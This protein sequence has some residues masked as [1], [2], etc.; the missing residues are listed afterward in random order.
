M[1]QSYLNTLV[2]EMVNKKE[3]LKNHLVD[4][5]FIGGGTP[6][7]L[8][9]GGIEIIINAIKQNFTVLES[10]EITMEINP[11]AITQELANEWKQAGI[12]RVSVGLQSAND[13]VLKTIGRTHKTA[14]FVSAMQLLKNAGFKNRNADLML[15]LPN[16]TVADVKNAVNLV[17]KQG[18]THVSA[19][20]LILEDETPLQKLVE[21]NLVTLPSEEETV[22]MYD[23]VYKQLKRHGFHRYEVSNFSKIGYECKHNVNCWNLKEYVGF[24]A[25][26]HSFFANERYSNQKGIEPYMQSIAT[27]N[28]AKEVSESLSKSQLAEETLLLG[29]RLSSGISLTHFNQT[30]HT[31]LLQTKQKTIREFQKLKLL[32]VKNNRLFVTNMGFYVLN[33]L[34]LDLVSD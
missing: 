2:R 13:Q 10:A 5:I 25:G 8:V 19:Y 21:K 29:L 7:I 22:A 15:G 3:E 18:V 27:N 16:Q 6:S 34:I 17:L 24:G 32:K 28:H 30:F 20:S 12:N 33:K 26:A 14:D 9:H 31:N 4:T 23:T 1:E 11:N